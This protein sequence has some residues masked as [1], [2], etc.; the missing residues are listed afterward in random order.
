MPMTL[1]D[2]YPMIDELTTDELDALRDYV[3][4]EHERRRLSVY[5]PQER[6]RRIQEAFSALREGLTPE[7]LA[8]I[9][10]AMNEESIEPFDE[11]EW[12]D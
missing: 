6:I 11:S 10:Q 3:E 7:Q 12:R 2:L 4:Q 1:S 5:T 9:T 8:S